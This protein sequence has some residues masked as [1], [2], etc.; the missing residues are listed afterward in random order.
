M[1]SAMSIANRASL[2]FRGRQPFLDVW[3]FVLAAT[4]MAESFLK[5]G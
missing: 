3:E 5:S 2:V 4:A 1:L